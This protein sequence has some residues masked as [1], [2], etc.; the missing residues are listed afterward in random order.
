MGDTRIVIR[1]NNMNFLVFLGV[2]IALCGKSILAAPNPGC[3]NRMKSELPANFIG[4]IAHGSHSLTKQ[5]V[6]FYFPNKKENINL[7]V[8]NPYLSS[9][10]EI[11]AKPV[12]F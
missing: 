9:E 5:D 11:L 6:Q 1:R 2:F 10:T 4:V 7:P 12:E 8:V 3:S